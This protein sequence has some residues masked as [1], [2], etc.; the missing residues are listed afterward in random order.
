M[1]YSWFATT[2]AGLEDLAAEEARE[3]AEVDASPDVGK[4][5]FE[6]SLEQAALLNLASTMLHR[7]FLLLAREDVRDLEDV[8]RVARRLD[9]SW[10]MDS[11][12]SFA[13]RAERHAK[14]L[15]FTSM[16]AAAVVGRAVIESFRESVGVRLRVNLDEPDLEFYCL[17]R[18]SEML[19]GLDSTGPSLHR[20][21]YRVY[22]H[23]AALHPTIAAGMLRLAGWKRE[24]SLL[25]PMCGGGTIPIE[26]ALAARR[27]PPG[28]R[29]GGLSMERFRFVGAE[30]L[31]RARRMA[32]DRVEPGYVAR[33]AGSDAS[34]RSIEGAR[35]NAEAA[36]VADTVELLVA[37]AL[38]M[39]SWLSWEPDHVL[40]N[41]PYGLRMGV[42]RPEEF[43]RRFARSLREASPSSKLTAIVSKPV[44]FTRSIEAEGY[45]VT[46]RRE[47]MYGRLRAAIISA[48]R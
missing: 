14:Q 29:R 11:G 26:A 20:R 30:V 42:R 22:H 25:D 4:I 5:F 2:V 21:Y 13:V 16:D 24:E 32:E 3:I 28:L 15:P 6:G 41:P 8:F 35:G 48:E 9:Y 19:L 34:P 38:R 12:Q 39:E 46:L 43:Y 10:L 17:L 45:R 40:V 36:G 31:E 33:I 44:V 47:V 23:R 7:V 18:D 1:R 27:I 37:D